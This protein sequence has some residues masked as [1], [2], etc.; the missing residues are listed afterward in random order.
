MGWISSAWE[1]IK[2]G[3][4]AVV[5]TAIAATKSIATFVGEV[6][7]LPIEPLRL[8]TGLIIK[9]C[10]MLGIIKT[11]EKPEEL[12]D[13]VLQAHD[14]GI[15]PESCEN[16]E[17]YKKK[18]E[19]FEL[20]PEKSGKYDKIDKLISASV[21]CEG[22][23]IHKYGFGLGKLVP[24]IVKDASFQN[25]E[26]IFNLFKSCEKNNSTMDTMADY[27]NR[28]LRGSERVNAKA[29]YNEAESYSMDNIAN[30]FE[31]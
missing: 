9:V 18:I 17:E 7:K 26:K 22:A 1:G 27:L 28:D 30:H 20:D 4:K 10:Q 2:S 16:Y 23:L 5:N 12:G 8:V 21:Y 3:C 31:E 15:T 11:D 13:K 24:I 19:N 29:V 25:P 14:K 6:V